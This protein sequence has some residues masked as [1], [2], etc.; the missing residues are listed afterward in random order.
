MII[1]YKFLNRL[2]LKDLKVFYFNIISYFPTKKK[3]YLP[4]I[5]NE[6]ILVVVGVIILVI[7]FAARKIKIKI[8][9]TP[10]G[11]SFNLMINLRAG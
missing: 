3:I 5:R 2:I 7:I 9:S 1:K 10:I 4:F 6:T 11:E 8:N